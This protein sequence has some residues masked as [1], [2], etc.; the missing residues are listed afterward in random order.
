MTGCARL[1]AHFQASPK[2]PNLHFASLLFFPSSPSEPPSLSLSPLARFIHDFQGGDPSLS[3]SLGGIS[4]RVG[5]AADCG[6]GAARRP[7]VCE[8][9]RRSFFE[10]AFEADGEEGGT[11]KGPGGDA[12]L[13]PKIHTSTRSA[14]CV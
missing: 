1:E 12:F 6:D 11:N 2:D 14:G 13:M 8:R 10:A 9:E 4:R 3:L 7:R 5:R